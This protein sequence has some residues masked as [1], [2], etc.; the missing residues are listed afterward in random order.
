MFVQ[1]EKIQ[2]EEWLLIHL[3]RGIKVREEAVHLTVG[4]D[5][6]AGTGDVEI[7][8][9]LARVVYMQRLTDLLA[10]DQNLDLAILPDGVIDLLAFLGSNV[11][12][13]LWRY[14]RGVE[15]IVA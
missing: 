5:R 7:A 12:D 4:E 15:D 10:L 14:L 13:V 1:I 8:E 6:D 2:F 3:V 9:E 11:T